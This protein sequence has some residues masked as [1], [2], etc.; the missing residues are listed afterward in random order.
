MLGVVVDERIGC[1]ILAI[2]RSSP[3]WIEWIHVVSLERSRCNAAR[4]EFV[5]FPK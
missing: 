3:N 4:R 1:L 5:S 2:L